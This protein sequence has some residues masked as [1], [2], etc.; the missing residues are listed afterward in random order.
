MEVFLYNV[1]IEV[2]VAAAIVFFVV[3]SLVWVCT[4][5]KLFVCFV[6]K[7][8]SWD[9]TTSRDRELIAGNDQKISFFTPKTRYFPRT[10]TEME[11]EHYRKEGCV[12]WLPNSGM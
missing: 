5:F 1:T 12:D 10:V 3:V 7:S 6:D 4:L 2:S 11:G 9:S 8:L